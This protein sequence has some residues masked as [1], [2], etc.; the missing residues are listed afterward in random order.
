MSQKANHAREMHAVMD[1][2]GGE[3]PRLLLHACCAPCSSSVLE[4][5]C[6]AFEVTVLYNPNI[7]PPE[8][9]RRRADELARF[10][11]TSGGLGA[12]LVEAPYVPEEFARAVRG[13]ESE[14]ERG[15]R[16]TA[17]YRLRMEYAARY[18][19]RHGFGWFCTTLSVSPHKD[20][21][22]IN[23]IG[24]QL[25]ERYGV[26]HLPNDFKK[27][28]GYLRSLQL[29]EQYALYRQEYCGCEYSA[30]GRFAGKESE[31]G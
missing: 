12:A 7:W 14:P 11:Q 23:T 21:E 19:A 3:R 15:G 29:S 5:L 4:Q 25:E 10:L 17:C 28:N 16:C 24:R 30:Q 1:A 26:R 13:L 6:R 8:E 2:L 31:N 20:A 9:Y 18:A 27:Q 22:R